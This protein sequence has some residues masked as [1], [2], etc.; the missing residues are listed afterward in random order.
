MILYLP[1]RAPL[2]ITYEKWASLACVQSPLPFDKKKTVL[3][4]FQ[5]RKEQVYT[6]LSFLFP[7]PLGISTIMSVLLIMTPSVSLPK[8]VCLCV[9]VGGDGGIGVKKV[10]YGKF[11][12][13]Y[14]VMVTC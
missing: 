6:S 11:M 7:L 12:E 8:C 14:G 3:F 13:N 10:N 5:E 4:F 1:S 2:N 9:H